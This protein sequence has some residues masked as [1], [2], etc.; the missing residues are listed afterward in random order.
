[1][2]LHELK[3]SL[4]HSSEL[5]DLS[6]PPTLCVTGEWQ[7]SGGHSPREEAHLQQ[8]GFLSGSLYLVGI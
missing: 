3:G 1:M 2:T 4:A 7:I 8:V 5:I 6:F